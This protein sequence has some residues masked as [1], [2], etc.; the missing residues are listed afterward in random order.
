[1]FDREGHGFITVPD[2]QDVLQKLGEKLTTDE[3]EVRERERDQIIFIFLTRNLF[4][5]RTLTAPKIDRTYL[6]MSVCTLTHQT[7]AR[8]V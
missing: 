4:P 8:S 3:C 7:L 1:M 5:K 2:L 6:S